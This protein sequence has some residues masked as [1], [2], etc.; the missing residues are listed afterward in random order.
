MGVGNFEEAKK[1][2]F[3]ALK[4]ADKIEP[5]NHGLIALLN[6]Q[7]GAIQGHI[8]EYE[9]VF[10]F[11][12]FFFFFFFGFFF[13]FFFGFFFFFFFWIFFFFFFWIFFFFFFFFWIFFFFFFFFFFF[14]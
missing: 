3:D 2:Y 7:C 6:A 8:G 5:P 4:L 10:G 12:F 13:F 1:V 11:F 9:Q 14:K